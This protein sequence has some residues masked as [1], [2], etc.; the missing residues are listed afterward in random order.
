MSDPRSRARGGPGRP[1]GVDPFDTTAEIDPYELTGKAAPTPDELSTGGGT[2]VT[3]D[4]GELE[5]TVNAIVTPDE[6][7]DAGPG[8]QSSACPKCRFVGEPGS[9][10]CV[11]CGTDMR[12]RAPAGE[13]T[14]TEPFGPDAEAPTPS[15]DRF[16]LG[17]PRDVGHCPTCEAAIVPG[18]TACAGCGE[19]LGERVILITISP[20]GTE[21]ERL[22]PIGGV[23]TLGRGDAD[24]PFPEDPY[25]SPIHARVL[26]TAGGIVVQD[27]GSLNGTFLR[28]AKPTAVGPGDSFVVGRQ[29]LRL[30]SAGHT[31]VETT[32]KDGTRVL[33]SPP[34]EGDL[35]L[36]QLSA[37]GRVQ[38]RYH[39]PA[40]GAVLGRDNGEVRFPVDPYISG[41]HATVTA[42]HGRTTLTDLGSSNGTWLRL[43]RAAPVRPGDEIYLGSQVLRISRP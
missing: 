24:L 29:L 21:A 16:E 8:V 39:L 35:V 9:R 7:F 3:P 33:G 4:T 12:G 15:P 42:E 22:P 31:H 18:H 14:R 26:A 32:G 23:A 11:H 40:K 36:V 13:R 43:R 1:D 38:D 5:D 37:S 34:P 6:P 27:L 25:L 2:A 30:E 19:P 10:Y 17:A 28:L 41:R 20:D